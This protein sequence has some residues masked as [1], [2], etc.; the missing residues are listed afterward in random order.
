MSLPAAPPRYSTWSAIVA[1]IK[2][3]ETGWRAYA[4][5][6]AL[7][8]VGR[9][10]T[11]DGDFGRVTEDNLKAFQKKSG[12]VNDGV[13]GPRT[14]GKLIE[15]ISHEV[16]ETFDF[17]PDGLMQ[18]YAEAEG[19]NVLAATNWFTPA[20]GTPGV[21][22]GVVQWRR[23]GP[24]FKMAELRSAFDC[25]QSME[26]ASN[27]LETRLMDYNQRR[28]SL[29][30]EL[31]LRA[32]LLAHNAPFM[33]EQIVRNGRLSTPFAL[34]TWTVKPGGGHYT[35]AEWLMVYTNKLMKYATWPK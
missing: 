33:A 22:C 26:Y 32:A 11:A 10:V 3:G 25:E 9:P 30:D 17:L 31:V 14:Q 1:P 13:A 29:S 21:D 23:Y 6:A 34:A 2:R 20:G 35:H 7:R 5:Q 27:I 8:S 15:K 24:P 16:H 12:L 19:A 28:P 4:L 18:G